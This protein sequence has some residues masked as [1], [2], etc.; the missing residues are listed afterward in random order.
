MNCEAISGAGFFEST[1]GISKSI[2]RLI[3]KS[4]DG[5][6]SIHF[7]LQTSSIAVVDRTGK[8][9]KMRYVQILNVLLW[10]FAAVTEAFADQPPLD[11]TN[12]FRPGP[13]RGP[14]QEAPSPSLAL[15]AGPVVVRTDGLTLTGVGSVIIDGGGKDALTIAGASGVSL[16]GFEVLNG[17]NGILGVNGAHI[18]LTGVNVH[19]NALF[20]I[21]LQTAS[22]A[23]LS[24]VTTTRNGRHGLDLQTG[25]VATITETFT[26]SCNRVFGINAN[27]S[28]LTFSAATATVSGNALG[29]Q[30]ATG[31]NAFL[32]D[33]KTVING[34][35]NLAVGLTVVQ[36]HIWRRSAGA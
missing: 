10:L 35:D 9:K 20:C 18:T 36:G 32:N 2:T 1:A 12:E 5:S 4:R 16:A 27:G 19:D 14:R 24:G 17:L 31:A 6:R 3:G 26:S 28:S 22:S 34:N 33:S 29:I 8:D 25:S 21:S 13:S 23:L 7:R 11:C 15:C 30:V